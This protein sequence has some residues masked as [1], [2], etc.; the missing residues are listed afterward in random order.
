MDWFLL[1]LLSAFCAATVDA[2]TKRYYQSLPPYAMGLIRLVF[3]LPWLVA[4]MP[5]I[6][7]VKPDRMFYI[8]LAVGL[9]LETL[10]FFCYMQAIR[11]SPLSLCLPFLAFTPAFIILTGWLILGET[12]NATG[13]LGIALIVT[14]AYVLNLFRMKTGILAPFRE[15][16]RQQGPRLML[17]TALLYAM[18]SVLG[19]TAILH[20]NPY[21]FGVVYFLTFTIVIT[22]L[23]ALF[24]GRS[25][26]WQSAPLLPGLF[27]GA[28]MAAMIFS[29]MLAISKVE[30]AFMI[31]VKRSSML[32][33]ALYGIFWFREEAPGQRFAGVVIMLAGVA[34]VGWAS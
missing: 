13:A 6:P 18:T 31:A 12:I 3:A 10:A 11:L 1:S 5:F 17:C 27:I 26:G 8:C 23:T 4:A 15:I 21:F 19:K 30:A 25:L 22:T 33:G 34:L 14:G 32:F 16:F 28:L 24:H 20:S 2:L 9:P 7:L 29:H